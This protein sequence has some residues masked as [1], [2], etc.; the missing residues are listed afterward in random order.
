RLT[1]GQARALGFAPQ[2]ALKAPRL[3]RSFLAHLRR[4]HEGAL[5]DAL[6]ADHWEAS[7]SFIDAK[8]GGGGRT[9]LSPDGSLLLEMSKE[10][11]ALW[12]TRSNKI[13]RDLTGEEAAIGN[14][15]FS[16]DGVLMALSNEAS[17]VG[18]L[19]LD[20]PGGPIRWLAEPTLGVMGFQDAM[21]MR[22]SGDGRLLA[23]Y[24]SDDN[25]VLASW[26]LAGGRLLGQSSLP[27][28]PLAISP[29][30]RALVTSHWN[31]KTLAVHDADG[32]QIFRTGF[33]RNGS[34]W[35]SP[36]HAV[37]SAD[38]RRLA[39]LSSDDNGKSLL[40]LWDV[41]SG[42]RIYQRAA[43]LSGYGPLGFSPDGR[44]IAVSGNK[45]LLVDPRDGEEKSLVFA[46]DKPAVALGM[47]P[48]G[49]LHLAHSVPGQSGEI[50]KI[51]L[52]SLR[53]QAMV[54]QVDEQARSEALDGLARIV[55]EGS[56]Q[57][58]K[59]LAVSL[60]VDWAGVNSALVALWGRLARLLSSA[61]GSGGLKPLGRKRW[62][63][64]AKDQMWRQLP[65]LSLILG[66][67]ARLSVFLT[68]LSFLRMAVPYN[69][70]NASALPTMAWSERKG[71]QYALGKLL[72]NPVS[73]SF[74]RMQLAGAGGYAVELKMPGQEKG[75]DWISPAH[76]EVAQELLNAPQ[77]EG[78]GLAPEPLFF[79]QWTGTL[80]LY[81]R[82]RR[83]TRSN[84]L[85]LMIFRYEDGKRLR[86]TGKLVD[87]LPLPL[88]LA[89]PTVL[90]GN[91]AAM[92]LAHMT[93]WS[94]SRD[95][96]TDAHSENAF[97][98]A[99]GRGRS[100]GD[101]GAFFKPD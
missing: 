32:R 99:D 101:F 51:W 61:N 46:S 23:A 79:G 29:D 68:A 2:S 76:F 59:R 1:R 86:N 70:A 88:D 72:V 49:R 78:P 6:L 42:R 18:L 37:F 35:W 77:G 16:E 89:A 73:E 39:V 9:I 75:R 90:A 60:G 15:A 66:H 22:F 25:S 40:S 64:G 81:G 30:G 14:G 17:Q 84:P 87:W 5:L 98:T 57:E 26:E 3:I 67:G 24:D 10:R 28:F 53:L 100:A 45:L 31:S 34:D 47:E 36:T 96:M 38:G 82:L 97:V 92:M 4:A 8:S 58:L 85:G 83:F 94:G 63:H 41:Q 20:N 27:G 69:L 91:A 62:G 55:L 65:Q 13:L 48:A 71:F 95:N 11:T 93:G 80:R 12:D 21:A 7:D 50:H 54:P 56:E 33:D 74:R 43:P 52:P 44:L 19:D